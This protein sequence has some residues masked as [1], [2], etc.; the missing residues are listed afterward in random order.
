MLVKESGK[1]YFCF[2]YGGIDAI[3]HHYGTDSRYFDSEVDLLF[4]TM[5]RIFMK[6]VEGKIED[7]IIL[8]SADHGQT[9]VNPKTTF[10]LNREI[11][12]I[13]KYLK[14]TK[15]GKPI[16]PAGSCRD[17][18][19]HVKEDSIKVLSKILIHKLEGKAEIFESEELIQ[20][21]FFGKKNITRI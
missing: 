9:N 3:G 2:Y 1:S 20:A 12:D 13:S 14:T 8:L 17:M 16:V 7:T 21:G 15:Q 11:Q 6:F 5:E 19:L 10:Y 18:F 4:T